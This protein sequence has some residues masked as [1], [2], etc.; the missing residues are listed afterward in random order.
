MKQ[1]RPPIT[2]ESIEK[3]DSKDGG[4]SDIDDDNTTVPPSED[5]W[6]TDDEDDDSWWSYMAADPKL[7]TLV[8]EVAE[9]SR[10]VEET[11]SNGLINH[12][13]DVCDRVFAAVEARE[14]LM[15]AKQAAGIHPPTMD[16]IGQ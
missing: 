11:R 16:H 2:K 8:Q 4:S 7:A 5:D 3:S 13:S 6:W 15:K 9:T 12:D 10:A 14:K 1:I